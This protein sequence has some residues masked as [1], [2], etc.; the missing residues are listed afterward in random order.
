MAEPYT[1]EELA[2]GRV[3]VVLDEFL[4]PEAKERMRDWLWRLVATLDRLRAERDAAFVDARYLADCALKLDRAHGLIETTF[5]AGKAALRQA[6][7]EIVDLERIERICIRRA[8]QCE[9]EEDHDG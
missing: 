2:S 4:P 8:T 6:L 9:I 1:D 7:E 5:E 3:V